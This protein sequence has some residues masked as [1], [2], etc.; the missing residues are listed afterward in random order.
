[1]TNEPNSAFKDSD[2]AIIGMAC[3]FPGANNPRSFWQNL[4]NGVESISVFRDDE[5]AGPPEDRQHTAFVKAGAVLSE[6][7]YFDAAFFGYSPREVELLDP[8]QR[9]FMECAWEAIESAGYNPHSYEGL[10]GVYAGMG[11][12][13]YLINNV[14]PHIG[15]RSNR[16][17]LGSMNDL[18]VMIGNDK[19]YLPSRVSYK[20]N[21]RGPSVNVQTA[22]STS[23]VAVHLACQSLL[24]GECDMALAGAASILVP[25]KSGYLYQEDMVF[26]PDGHCRVFDARAQGTVFGSGVGVV[27]LKLLRA[28]L[29]DGDAVHAV[30]KGTAINNDGAR[31]VGYTAPSVEGQSAV[32]AEALAMADVDPETVTYVEAHGTGTALGDPIEVTALT[33]A[34]NSKRK[35]FCAI[36]SV[37][38]NLGHL[39][40]AAGMAGLIKTVLTLENKLIPPS[41]YFEIPNPKIDFENSPFHVN[42]RLTDWSTGGFP[43]RAGVSAFGIGGTNAHVVLQEGPHVSEKRDTIDRDWHVVTLSARSHA[44]LREVASRYET[45]LTETPEVSLADVAFTANTGR[46]QFEHRLA[47]VARTAAEAAEQLAARQRD[48]NSFEN[49]QLEDAAHD[50]VTAAAHSSKRIAFLFTGQGS[51][52]VGMGRRLY[53][54]N[55]VFRRVLDEC[56]EESHSL[57]GRSLLNILYPPKGESSPIDEIAFSQPALFAIELALAETWKSW[58]IEPDAV[59]GHSLGEYVAACVAG[60]LSPRDGLRLIAERGRLMQALP[61]DAEMAAVRADERTVRLVIGDFAH[62]VSIAADNGP[63]SIVVSGRRSYMEIVCARLI[64]KDIKVRKLNIARAGHSPAIEPMLDD[65]ERLVSQIRLTPPRIDVISNITGHIVGKEMVTPAYWRAHTRQTVRFKTGMENL[66]ASGVGVFIEIGP[67][68]MLLGMGREC[69]PGHESIWLPSLRPGQDDWQQ[70]ATSLGELFTREVRVDWRA[71]DQGFDRRRLHLP[72]YPFQRQ[73]YW[74]GGENF[75]EDGQHQADPESRCDDKKD[76]WKEWLYDI[77]WKEAKLQAG[78]PQSFQVGKRSHG[79]GEWIIFADKRGTGEELAKRFALVGVGCTIIDSGRRFKRSAGRCTLDPNNPEHFQRM[80]ESLD[81]APQGVVHLWSLDTPTFARKAED[82]LADGDALLEA[83]WSSCGSALHLVKAMVQKNATPST[84]WWVTR[85]AQSVCPGHGI[86]S[87]AQ[88]PLWGMARVV[89]MEHPELRCV[90][91]D[92]DP[93]PSDMDGPHLFAEI[94]NDSSEDMVAFRS[95]TRWVARLER[96]QSDPK[97]ASLTIKRDGSYLI[98]GGLGGVGLRLAHWMAERGAGRL[99]L[100]GRND[101]SSANSDELEALKRAGAEVVIIRTDVSDARQVQRLLENADAPTHPL[102]GV[103]HA[104]GVLDDG[105]VQQMDRDRFL[106][107]F[108]P[109]VQGAWNLHVLISSRAIELDFLVL[110]SSASAL[111]GNTGQANHAAAN[112]FMDALAYDLRAQG[113]KGLAINWG[114]WADVGALVGKDEARRRLQQMGIASFNSVYGLEALEFLLTQSSCQVGVIPMDWVRFL[115]HHRLEG[116][117][118]FANCQHARERKPNFSVS[119]R[120]KLAQV[121]ASAR[122][123][124]LLPHVRALAGRVLGLRTPDAASQLLDDRPLFDY[125][126]DSLSSIE[127]RNALQSSLG[128]TLPATLVFDHRTVASIVGHLEALPLEVEQAEV[129]APANISTSALPLSPGQRVPLS[130]QQVRWLRLLKAGYGRLLVPIVFDTEV[131]PSAFREALLFVVERHE[132]LRYWYPDGDEACVV[133]A[134]VIVPPEEELFVDLT[135]MDFEARTKA[136]REHAQQCRDTM[137]NPAERPS[138]MI[139]CLKLPNRRCVALLAVQHLEFDGSSIS[140]FVDELREAYRACSRDELPS[141]A[142]TVPYREYVQWQQKY[143]SGGIRE[144]RAFFEGLYTSLHRVTTLHGHNGFSPTQS[145]KSG[146]Y[147]PNVDPGFGQELLQTSNKLGVS[148]FSIL[149]AA[150]GDLIA[151]VTE[152]EEVVIGTIVNGR[153]AE[154]FKKTIGPFVAP[155]PIR[156]HTAGQSFQQIA[157]QCHHLVAAINGRCGYPVADLVKNVPVFKDLP[158]ETYFTDV[159]I[160]FN[161]YPRETTGL[162][163]KGEVLE[164]LAPIKDPELIELDAEWLNEIAGLFLII[165]LWNGEPRFNFWYHLH[166]FTVEQVSDWASRYIVRLRRVLMDI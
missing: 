28:A 109:K 60:V 122:R 3:R 161:N 24:N 114:P 151:E 81:T 141:F 37:K 117:G 34:F 157:R 72:T 121:P 136:L 147:T 25:Q 53:E 84:V 61:D 164:C 119:F 89:G 94:H 116:V 27:L 133:S 74:I 153:P 120:R 106:K 16:N 166:R 87:I 33:R 112:A 69:L 132:I 160:M 128:C 162:E 68:P 56:D 137:P 134:D 59:M 23:L 1:M 18:L 21:L 90:R 144:D 63:E 111:V 95:V 4:R 46:K 9:L 139:R 31:K 62:A 15:F 49:N 82:L 101:L 19:D 30:I 77:R 154:R 35:G 123:D 57:L 41:L 42:T 108:A 55:S 43:R 50:G 52:Y 113:R 38:S 66:G 115:E 99:I 165:D 149:L 152:T 71:F 8:Q 36:G 67:A 148:M 96:Y 54:T 135:L 6:V 158:I 47:V 13:T 39:G 51:Q 2:I 107:V 138:W 11:M 124:V 163:V 26:S 126:L 83:A 70:L 7:E 143:L 48:A 86:E 10:L 130:S 155:F 159:F 103:I 5:V 58:G 79:T 100:A 97:P 40:W 78:A 88:A 102:R 80:F 32:I 142:P 12:S 104:A 92:L 20:L 131:N 76:R 98:T 17:F 14:H 127:L 150:Y 22:C 125:G 29:V 118:F 146:R 93:V 75:S 145:F 140:V 44:A 105:V 110:F 45:Y 73:R 156:I 85:G 129:A 91:V 64:E 65:F